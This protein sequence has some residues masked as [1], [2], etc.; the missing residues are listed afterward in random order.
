MGLRVPVGEGTSIYC[1]VLSLHWMYWMYCMPI[2]DLRLSMVRFIVQNTYM[3][4]EGKCCG[5]KRAR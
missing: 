2:S 1:L 3:G 4:P 5:H